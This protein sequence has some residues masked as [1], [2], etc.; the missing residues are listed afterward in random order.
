MKS[1]IIVGIAVVMSATA[2]SAAT[3]V[4]V[5][6]VVSN[7]PGIKVNYTLAGDPA[8]VTLSLSSKGVSLP[9][10]DLASV[11]GDVNAL[12][13][14]GERTIAW[15][16][17]PNCSVTHYAPSELDVAVK[18]WAVDC[19]PDYMVVDLIYTNAVRYYTSTNAL[20]HS[21]TDSR[22]KTDYLV[23][24]RIPAAGVVWR[25]GSP[26]DETGRTANNEGSRYV[27]LESDYYMGIYE[28]TEGQFYRIYRLDRTGTVGGNFF[29]PK[30]QDGSNPDEYPF[31]N[32]AYLNLRGGDSKT[33]NCK[34]WPTDEH[35]IGTP[36]ATRC[37]LAYF[38]KHLGI[39]FDL[40]SDPQWE[41][42]CR[43]GADGGGVP[44]LE[45]CAWYKDN[46]LM[47]SSL[48]ECCFLH[49]VG[50]K[51][52]NGYGLYDMLGNAL[53]YCL[54]YF[55]VVTQPDDPAN[56]VLNETELRVANTGDNKVVLRGGSYDA[57]ASACRPAWKAGGAWGNYD[58]SP[59]SG[60][61]QG[62][63]KGKSAGCRLVCPAIAVK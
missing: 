17:A 6:S 8:V 51:K 36:S 48:G 26:T 33:D 18:A 58:I 4:T 55:K 19:P 31:C 52:P 63:A 37:W 34:V 15:T 56:T 49:P 21:V 14:P 42:A 50:G 61:D 5:T 32:Y 3:T 29:R 57:K 46:S 59:E 54:D 62:G 20:P 28:L 25:M 44:D 16:P 12:I 40:P 43:G 23:M 60:W 1:I 27:K 38:R 39:E 2:A 10:A 11:G 41:F 9:D 30:I 7:G 24:R 35:E 45:T 13:Q 22:Y 47:I 53:E